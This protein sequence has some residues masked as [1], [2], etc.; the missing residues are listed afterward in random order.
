MKQKRSIDYKAD[1][2][3][4]VN[5]PQESRGS[6]ETPS[7]ESV[8]VGILRNPELLQEIFRRLAWLDKE[9]L[10]ELREAIDKALQHRQDV[11]TACAEGRFGRDYVSPPRGVTPGDAEDK[12]V[13]S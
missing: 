10:E 12:E 6:R 4:H 5:E 13:D 2:F 8:A 7:L 11:L 9:Q 3:L 1:P